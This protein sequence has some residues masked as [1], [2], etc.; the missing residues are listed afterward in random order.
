MSLLLPVPA[1]RPRRAWLVFVALLVSA[2]ALFLPSNGAP[3]TFP[4]DPTLPYA[5]VT[6]NLHWQLHTRGLAGLTADDLH[7]FPMR[8]DRLVTD[9]VPVDALASWPFAAA[10]G[11]ATGMWVWALVTL[12]AVGAAAAWLGMRWWGTLGAGL[13][14]G[15]GYQ[16]GEALLR[17]V[18][19]GRPTQAFAAIFLP[20]AL[21]LG[22]EAARRAGTGATRAALGAGLFA[23]IGTLASWNLG[24]MFL[25]AAL[26]PMGLRVALQGRSGAAGGGALGT[27]LVVFTAFAVLV[28]PALGWMATGR[29]EVPSLGMDPWQEVVIGLRQVRPVDL[30]AARIY[31]LEG[32]ALGTLGRPVLLVA[33]AWAVWRA[34]ARFVALPLATACLLA[35]LGLGAWLPGPVAL[36]WGWLQALPGA[37]RLWW[38]DRSWIGVA[39]GLSLLAA[40]TPPRVAF[41]VALGVFGEA[42]ALSR[43]LP[44]DR[45]PLGPS[46]SA[47]VL[48]QAPHVPFVL[49]P[50]GQG[51]FR[52]DRL[53]LVD[54]LR[55]G[56]PMAN[57]TRP[58][59]DLT[60]SD[61]VLR[62]WR[63]NA[64]LRALLACEI[65]VGASAS[66][67]TA[68]PDTE[69]T[70]TPALVH[71]GLS[72]VY[73][74][75]RYV[76]DDPAYAACI[77]GVLAG[78]SR[79]EEPPLVR[80]RAP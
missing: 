62:N 31:G 66:D 19:D 6:L 33:A 14:A 3:G 36:P 63:N 18:G 9:G 28:L 68:T 48:A 74:D 21:G 10:F 77:E 54:Q 53:D 17:E 13:V 49:L 20:L 71:A 46:P 75:P 22:A 30:A 72:E 51:P 15:V 60:S 7:G 34:R 58:V 61:A 47:E 37:A 11:E 23:G 40:G 8:T 43:A 76:D 45:V 69:A 24:P 80:F 27:A 26:G 52:S 35:L 67:M 39:L 42:W 2:W 56:R 44:F 50:T 64:G 38:P 70:A 5:P 1:P 29:S 59:L 78:W 32:V 55:H 16:V 4:G 12:W 73:L 25:L 57:G 79:S 41:L 65:G